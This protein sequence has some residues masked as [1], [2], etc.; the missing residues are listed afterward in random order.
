MTLATVPRYD[1]GQISDR[2][3]RAVVVG[4]GIA[5]LV[6]AR[7]LADAFDEVTV[8]DRDPLPDEPVARQGVPQARQIHILWEAGR[9][10]LE[11]FFPGYSEELRSAGGVVIDGRRD[12]YLFS[13]NGFLSPGLKPFPL[14]AATRPLYEQLLRR[15]VSELDGVHLRGN[16]Q[17]TTY[18]ADDAATTV[19]G[20]VVR[21]DNAQQEEL[22]ADLVVDA[23]G[24]TSRT[25]D[26][27]EKYGYTMPATEEV[28]VDL[29]Y[30]ATLIERPSD[31][32]RMIG[33]LAEAPRTRGGAVLPVEDN[34]WLVNLHGIHGDHPP[35]DVEDSD[36]FAASLP[37]PIVKDLLD[38]HPRMSEKSTFYPFPSSRRYR[39]EELNRFPDGLVVIGDAIASFNPIYGQGMSVAALEALMLHHTLATNDRQQ[40]G[41]RF[42]DRVAAVV[43]PAWMLAA[44]ADF[45][46][47]QT[48]GDRPRGTA[49]FNWYLARLLRKAHTDR[50]LTDA[51]TEVLSMQ[52]SP[53]SLLRPG[54][55]WR[56]L[57]PGQKD[58]QLPLREPPCTRPKSPR[59]RRD[60]SVSTREKQP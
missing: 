34:R 28:H 4:A 7:V 33:V 60:E 42:F 27:L 17:F 44:G 8:I 5:G 46:F 29:A 54:V 16:C 51:F 32:R 45:G 50:A 1:S 3:G 31:D 53:T 48:E 14:Y 30:T 22:A 52:Q 41:R 40:F 6:A 43:E 58:E 39:Y 38:E 36:D 19:N 2:E 56:V 25:P 55:L 35:T 59:R 24:R 18:L 37:T 9:A 49:F 57:R 13:Q 12:F 26:W 20:V 47:P 23:T 21:S 10:T 15:R 11:A